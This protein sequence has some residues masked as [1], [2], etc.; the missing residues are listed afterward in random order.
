MWMI[1]WVILMWLNTLVDI[2]VDIVLGDIDMDVDDTLVDMNVD[3]DLG[4]TDVVK[5]F[6]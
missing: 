6:G 5:Y 2:D 1:I 3:D 4:D